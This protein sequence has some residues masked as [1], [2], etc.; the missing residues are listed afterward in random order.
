MSRSVAWS[1]AVQHF[2]VPAAVHMENLWSADLW[3]RRNDAK[4]KLFLKIETLRL[5]FRLY[6]KRRDDNYHSYD[7][8]NKSPVDPNLLL[9]FL[10]SIAE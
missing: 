6:D 7:I 10:V 3:Q 8:D 2:C 1:S 4:Y 5:T 9:I